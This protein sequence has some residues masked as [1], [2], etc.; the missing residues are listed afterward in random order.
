MESGKPLSEDAKE[1]GRSL[2][3][4]AAPRPG[5]IATRFK[6]GVSGNPAGRPKIE[7]RV[8]RY[9]RRYDRR[10][11][12]VLASI[13][14]D[15]KAPMAERRRAAMD[16]ISVGSGRPALVQEIAGRDGAPGGPLVNINMG[17]QQGLPLS[18]ADAYKLMCANVIPA[19]GAHPAFHPAIEQQPIDAAKKI[20]DES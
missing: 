11:C 3:S 5:N 14:E 8:R 18:P 1:A 6:K 16:L 4:D 9:A 20:E 15:E 7:K 17:M 13:A 12:K 19:D 10:M 2:E